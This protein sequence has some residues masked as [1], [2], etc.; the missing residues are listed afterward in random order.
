MIVGG[1]VRLFTSARSLAKRTFIV[2]LYLSPLER[3]RRRNKGRRVVASIQ[4]ET[5][6]KVVQ[7][8]IKI[9]AANESRRSRFGRGETSGLERIAWCS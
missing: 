9:K 4:E 8:Q 3:R 7:S 6:K 2:K 1:C 5:K